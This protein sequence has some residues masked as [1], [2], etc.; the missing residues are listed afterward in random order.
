MIVNAKIHTININ[1]KITSSQI[2]IRIL[3]QFFHFFHTQNIYN[4]PKN[5]QTAGIAPIMANI[6]M[7]N[8]IGSQCIII[9]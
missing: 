6:T 8:E 3:N 1:K 4:I 5:N 2:Q 7:K 9:F